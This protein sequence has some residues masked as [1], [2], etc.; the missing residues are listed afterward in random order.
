MPE[1]IHPRL[2]RRWRRIG[3]PLDLLQ[4]AY[5]LERVRLESGRAAWRAAAAR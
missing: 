3:K 4:R 5:P 2:L 1:V